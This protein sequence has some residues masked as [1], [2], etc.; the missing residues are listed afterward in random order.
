MEVVNW[1]SLRYHL[2]FAWLLDRWAKSYAQEK[3]RQAAE[4][5]EDL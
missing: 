3:H 4:E 1:K 5:A 2:G